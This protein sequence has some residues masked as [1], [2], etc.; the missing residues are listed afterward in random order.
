MKTHTLRGHAAPAHRAAAPA[1]GN[2]LA[3]E[4]HGGGAIVGTSPI[5]SSVTAGIPYA[6]NYTGL[7]AGTAYDVYCAKAGS[8]VGT[9]VDI[10]TAATNAITVPPAASKL[11]AT[12]VTITTTY[13]TTNSARCAKQPVPS[14]SLSQK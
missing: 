6:V 10:T 11:A 8:A 14:R 2:I 9:K 12:T 1:G 5:A 7:A 3:G 13:A 4:G